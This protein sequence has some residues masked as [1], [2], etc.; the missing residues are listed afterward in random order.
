MRRGIVKAVQDANGRLGDAA[1]YFHLGEE[2]TV[3]ANSRLLLEDGAISWLNPLAE[4]GAKVQPT[5]AFDPQL[6]VLD[7]RA[8]DGNRARWSSTTR[9]IRLERVRAAMFGR[10][11]FTA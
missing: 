1:F 3:G 9:R 8:P 2:R 5:D 10:R 4:A 6:P 11:A 7:F